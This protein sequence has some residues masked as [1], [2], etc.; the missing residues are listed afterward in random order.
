[1]K[2]L[3]Y[4]VSAE[5]EPYLKNWSQQNNIKV[6]LVQTPLSDNSVYLAQGY[7]GVS[8]VGM[9][10]VNEEVYATF[11]KFGIKQLAVR[12]VGVDNQDLQAAKKHHITITNV[13]SY[14]PRAIAEMGVT[15][16]MY[17]LRKIGIYQNRM[18]Q[19]NFTWDPTTVS[20]EIFNC[21]V[22]LI[23]TGHIGGASA[24]IYSA[25]G[26]KVIAYDPNYNADLEPYLTFTD[27]ETV[28]KTADIVSLHVPL[29]PATQKIIDRQAL[30]KMK[31][32]AIL[33]NV[34]RGE[35]V[36]TPALIA[37]LENRKIAA[38]GL[39]TLADEAK[40]IGQHLQ[41]SNLP[42]DYQILSQMPNVLLTPHV[43]F[44]TKLAVKNYIEIALNDA[45]T[46]IKGKKPRNL[47]C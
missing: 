44:F 41:A 20:T 11:E 24:Q 1:M 33:I 27:F 15:Q 34:A 40:L 5:E 45:V 47:I 39:D 16:A 19:G 25:L 46:V 38:A 26:A 22:G 12:Q 10:P 37:A 30:K 31:N 21:T 35:L 42:H 43:A 14:S 6:D 4:A 13:R 32:T 18:A 36:D 23:G 2:I 28:L 7:D 17:L 3:C 8:S 9:L 29:L